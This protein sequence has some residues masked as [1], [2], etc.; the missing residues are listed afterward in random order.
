M[1]RGAGIVA[2][3]ASAASLGVLTVAS[4][5]GTVNNGDSIITVTG[6][7]VYNGGAVPMG[8]ALYY[9]SGQDA[10]VSL[11]YGSALPTDGVIWAALPGNPA[12]LASQTANK[13]ITVAL[14]DTMSGKVVAGGNTTLVVKA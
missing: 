5:A 11:T 8:Y 7:Q 10:A 4:E 6:A 14:V 9:T 1:Q 2:T 12:T 13:K 3:M